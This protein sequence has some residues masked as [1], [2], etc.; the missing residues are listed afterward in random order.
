MVLND[1]SW[2]LNCFKF[3]AFIGILKLDIAPCPEEPK[4][5]LTPELARLHPYPDEK[6]RPTKEILE[7][8]VKEIYVPHYSYRNLLFVYPKDVNFSNR[9]GSARNITCKIQ[10]MASEE[11]HSALPVSNKTNGF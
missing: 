5:C 11:I 8:P 1:N 7:L 4:Y 9:P 6:G 2:Y 10:Y 3:S